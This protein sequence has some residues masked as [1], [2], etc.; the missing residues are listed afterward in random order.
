MIIGFCLISSRP[1][2]QFKECIYDKS[3]KCTGQDLVTASKNENRS[4]SALPKLVVNAGR[5]L[6]ELCNN[7]TGL[8]QGM[9][10]KSY[11]LLNVL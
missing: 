9:Y 8:H 10:E 3:L 5:V 1:A 11:D 4:I 6:E 7:N 2:L